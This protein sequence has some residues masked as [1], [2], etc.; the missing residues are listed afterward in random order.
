M[1]RHSAEA[2]APR[3][4]RSVYEWRAEPSCACAAYRRDH[5]R[6]MLTIHSQPHKA[7]NKQHRPKI[8]YTSIWQMVAVE[9][10][11]DY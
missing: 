1:S 5:Q 9:M 8:E 11:T 4:H 7:K 10:K 2:P 6:H 3:Q